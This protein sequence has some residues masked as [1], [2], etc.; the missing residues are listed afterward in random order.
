MC[1]TGKVVDRKSGDK[2]RQREGDEETDNM[3]VN[4]TMRKACSRRSEMGKEA[5]GSGLYNGNV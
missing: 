3:E 4:G 5:R 2:G 1:G